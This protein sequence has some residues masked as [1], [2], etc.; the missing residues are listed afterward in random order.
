MDIELLNVV[1]T[2]QQNAVTSDL[3]GNRINTWTDYYTCHATVSGEN[4]SVAGSEDTEA[5]LVA[6]H[7]KVDFT[8]RYCNAVKNLTTYGFR[9]V[10]NNEVYDIIG[11]DHMN[12]KRKTIK[13]R[14]RR[15]RQ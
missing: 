4:G 6:N 12:Y 5:G 2:I 11:I 7:S 13:L 1:L 15:E 3:I 14:C 8:I 9:V 10:F